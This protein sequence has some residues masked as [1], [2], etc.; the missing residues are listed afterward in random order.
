L[1]YFEKNR[2][3]RLPIPWERGAEI[4]PQECGSIA[5]SIQGFQLGESSEGR[6]FLRCA[7]VY[8]DRTG[9]DEYVPALKLFI[10]EEQRHA[11]DLGRFMEL[12]GIPLIKHTWPDTIF[13]WLRHR[14]G[15]EV[16]IAVLITAEIVAQVYYAALR[17]ATASTVLRRLCDQILSD[18]VEH[19]RFQAQRLAILRQNRSSW[20]LACLHGV[21]S[22]FMAG[23]SVVVWWKHGRALKAGGYSFCRFY[24]EIR[25]RLKTALCLMDP[26]RYRSA[27]LDCLLVEIDAEGHV[28]GR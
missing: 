10:A 3:S 11:R 13:R 6:H 9:D 8:A 4:T 7:Q 5:S 14:G 20:L 19:I 12:A 17:E 21:Q 28:A 16:S 22:F 1:E 15:L 18:E 27:R 26:R 23:T 25:Q 2:Q 24:R